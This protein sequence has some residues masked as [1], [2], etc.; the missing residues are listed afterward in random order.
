MVGLDGL[1]L[2]QLFDTLAQ[3]NEH[4]ESLGVAD[5]PEWKQDADQVWGMEP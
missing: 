4:L 5:L 1:P 2:N 3:W